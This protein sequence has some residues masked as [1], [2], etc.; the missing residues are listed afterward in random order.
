MSI[1]RGGERGR[2]KGREREREEGREGRRVEQCVS[3]GPVDNAI[4]GLV[5][6]CHYTD[7]DV[8]GPTKLISAVAM[9]VAF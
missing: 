8:P 6:T 1:E 5:G 2:E 9:S 7:G 4:R 3:R